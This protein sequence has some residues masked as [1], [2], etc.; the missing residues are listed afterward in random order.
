MELSEQVSII[1]LLR[2]VHNPFS[3]SFS[4]SLLIIIIKNKKNKKKGISYVSSLGLANVKSKISSDVKNRTSLSSERADPLVPRL[5]VFLR[6]TIMVATNNEITT[7]VKIP[8]TTPIIPG[9]LNFEALCTSGSS[10]L[11]S[12]SVEEELLHKFLFESLN[13]LRASFY[14]LKLFFKL[15]SFF[16]N[17]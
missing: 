17:A 5:Y 14:N 11:I 12:K 10:L 7:P 2:I 13:V 15:L 6:L 9:K 4:L 8:T 3:T 1:F 16:I